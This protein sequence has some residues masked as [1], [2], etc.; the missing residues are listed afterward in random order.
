ME[1]LFA[2]SNPVEVISGMALGVDTLGAEIALGMGIPL[3]AAVPFKGQESNWPP[4]S[5]KKYNSILERA[6]E[7]HVVTEDGYYA[8]HLFQKRNEWMVDR[9]DLVCAV[10]RGKSG[11]TANCVNYAMRQHVPVWRIDPNTRMAGRYNGLETVPR[12]ELAD[13]E[14]RL[15]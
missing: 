7:V 4:A 13:K 2:I 15:R 9:A 5:I 3:I 10:W 8:A 1:Y 11:G 6:S 12:N 14:V